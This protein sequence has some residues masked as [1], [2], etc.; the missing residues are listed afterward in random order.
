MSLSEQQLVDCATDGN[1]GCN[2][3]VM[4]SA[5]KYIEANGIASEDQYPYEA[6]EGGSCLE[7]SSAAQITGYE[8]VPTDEES[9]MRAVSEQPVS[10][11]VDAS[12]FQLYD[13]GVLS[14][15]CGTSRNHGVLVVGYGATEDGTK[16]QQETTD[17]TT[18]LIEKRQYNRKRQYNFKRQY[19]LKRHHNC[20]P[21][22]I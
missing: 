5:F 13:G 22:Y 7:A 2:G 16:A 21:Q 1:K 14:G 20:E 3:G 10:V 19:N 18:I 12:T 15:S 11:A 8:D 4:D 17:I 6:S 9:L